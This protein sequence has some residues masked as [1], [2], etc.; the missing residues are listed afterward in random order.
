MQGSKLVALVSDAALRERLRVVALGHPIAGVHA[1]ILVA[2]DSVAMGVRDTRRSLFDGPIAV[3]TY[4]EA[5]AL[6]ALDAGADEAF[7]LEATALDAATWSHLVARARLR[8]GIRGQTAQRHAALAERERLCALGRLVSGVTDELHGPL[9]NA[10]LS[11]DVLKRELDPLYEGIAQLRDLA[12]TAQPASAS[13]L[14]RLVAGLRVGASTPQ[15]AHQVLSDIS[16][17]CHAIALVRGDLGLQELGLAAHDPDHDRLER[18]EFVDLRD[19]LDRI[20]RLFRSSAGKSTLI[21]CDYAEDLPEVLAPRARIAQV[22]IGLLANALSSLRGVRREVHRVRVSLRADD[23]VVTV[24]VSDTGVGLGREAL[25]QIFDRPAH[26]RAELDHAGRELAVA[27]YTMRSLGGDLMAESLR[28]EG[29]TFVAWLPRPKQREARVSGTVPKP[30]FSREARRSV[31]VVEPH[32]HVLRALSHLLR[33]RYEVLLAT[34]G[35]EARGLIASGTRPDAIVV[36]V[37]DSDSRLFVEW[38]LLE[39]PELTRR[40]LLAADVSEPSGALLGL[41]Y[42][43]TPIEPAALFRGIE[44]RLVAPLRKTHG[45]VAEP[46]RILKRG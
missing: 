16:E 35:R 9:N 34:S 32:R 39:R 21:E 33:E 43:E 14:A 30:D 27:R 4:D 42:L 13:E 7:S 3:L 25:A 28:G 41:P 17:T 18:H 12:A 15:H 45:V 6:E 10:L 29:A 40:L 36:N 5:S 2:P 26:E 19:T 23:A 31:L 37:H 46:S 44:A 11:L 22:L 38:V 8:A 20:L 1:S 24:T